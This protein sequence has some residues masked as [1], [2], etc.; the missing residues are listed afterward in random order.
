M[1]IQIHPSEALDTRNMVK[2]FYFEASAKV[3]NPL[4]PGYDAPA[5]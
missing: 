5:S 2:S 1:A 4:P 3:L